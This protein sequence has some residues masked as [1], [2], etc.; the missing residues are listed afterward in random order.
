[1]K[2]QALLQCCSPLLSAAWLDDGSRAPL[3]LRPLVSHAPDAALLPLSAA[4]TILPLPLFSAG[5]QQL[6]QRAAQRQQQ[7]FAQR[8]PW[9][10]P[11]PKRDEYSKC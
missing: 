2:Q 1:M 11:L 3:L 7:H 5:G 9:P 4:A 8:L 10:L 6:W